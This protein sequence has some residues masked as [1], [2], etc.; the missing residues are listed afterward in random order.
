MEGGF[1][2]VEKAT[3][4][5]LASL[6]ERLPSA[7]VGRVVPPR[8]G[9][10]LNVRGMGCSSS[11][12]CAHESVRF[13]KRQ[14]RLRAARENYC[15]NAVTIEPL[16]ELKAGAAWSRRARAHALVEGDDRGGA[17]WSLEIP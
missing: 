14:P 8:T 13:V 12:V 5:E 2:P 10:L 6:F 7:C 9:D 3:N 1:D 15:R 4:F 17:M 11:P 16:T